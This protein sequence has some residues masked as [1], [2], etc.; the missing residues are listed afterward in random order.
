MHCAQFTHSERIE[1]TKKQT[2][3]LATG[4]LLF[5]STVQAFEPVA[6]TMNVEMQ[7]LDLESGTLTETLDLLEPSDADIQLAYN[8]LRTPHA[9]VFPAGAR[10]VELAFVQGVGFDGVTAESVAG[11]TF[12][13]EPVDLPFSANDTVVVRTPAGAVFKLGN[14]V[15]SA[16]SVIF[17]YSQVQ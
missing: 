8:A 17:N 9:V 10:G 11:L 16:E 4:A 5:V 7:A 1:M 3:L 6:V 14:A 2:T 12:S 13:M 15:E